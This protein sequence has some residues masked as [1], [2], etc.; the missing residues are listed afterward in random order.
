MC[1]LCQARDPGLT[2][3]DPHLGETSTADTARA[4]SLQATLPSYSLDQVGDQLTHGYWEST[5]RSYRAFD[6]S[7]SAL[8]RFTAT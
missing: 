5:G 8:T 4:D 6:V 2:S 1:L 7:P 3:Y